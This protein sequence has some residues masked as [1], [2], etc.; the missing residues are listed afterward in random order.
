[1]Q[2]AIMIVYLYLI[3]MVV[4]IIMIAVFYVISLFKKVPLKK[5]G[6]SVFNPKI[7]NT[8]WT[9]FVVLLALAVFISIN[10]VITFFVWVL[11]SVPLYNITP[12]AMEVSGRITPVILLLIITL[13]VRWGYKKFLK[14][15]TI[16]KSSL[17]K[18]L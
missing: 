11:I 2:I 6:E 13:E 14:S 10:V 3:A 8:L 5:L 17:K 15:N 9:I 4:G 12:N 1:M 18:K 16:N 7:W